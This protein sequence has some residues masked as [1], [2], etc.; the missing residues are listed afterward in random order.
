MPQK[1]IEREKKIHSWFDPKC[2]DWHIIQIR[3]GSKI[4]V[5]LPK[6]N[7]ISV[8][9]ADKSNIADAEN[10][11][12]SISNKDN[13]IGNSKIIDNASNEKIIIWRYRGT[14]ICFIEFSIW[15]LDR[16]LSIV[17][18]N[19]MVWFIIWTILIRKSSECRNGRPKGASEEKNHS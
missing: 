17:Y 19:L 12:L 7:K 10:L 13:L 6:S 11:N 16:L 3:K 14:F 4:S 2:I 18:K 15:V 9:I 5:E 1:I 8:G